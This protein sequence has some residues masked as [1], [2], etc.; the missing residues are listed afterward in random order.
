MNNSE[1]RAA[2]VSVC[3]RLTHSLLAGALRDEGNSCFG[4]RQREQGV[5][6]L[7]VER[8]ARSSGNRGEI[9]RSQLNRLVNTLHVRCVE[10]AGT[11]SV[12]LH[13]AIIDEGARLPGMNDTQADTVTGATHPLV[14]TF[15]HGQPRPRETVFLSPEAVI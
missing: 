13:T 15:S 11:F 8:E 7:A 2:N 5:H 9:D 6:R 1:A 3:S 10:F 14:L 12:T 4:S